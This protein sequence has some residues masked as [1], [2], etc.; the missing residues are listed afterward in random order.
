MNLDIMQLDN[1]EVLNVLNTLGQISN[2]QSQ[3][4][5]IPNT[6]SVQNI[7]ADSDGV[8]VAGFQPGPGEVFQ[9]YAFSNAGMNGR[10][11]SC[12]HNVF[13]VDV[14]NSKET[15]FIG[16]FHKN[17]QNFIVFV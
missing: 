3:S 12:T 2:T 8:K 17:R 9:A 1:L 4:G 11:G 5:P 15:Q 6:V 7:V 13:L 16:K 14:T 10:S